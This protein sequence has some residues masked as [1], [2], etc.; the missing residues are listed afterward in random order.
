MKILKKENTKLKK[1]LI[2]NQ[3]EKNNIINDCI[4]QKKINQNQSRNYHLN[5]EYI[6]RCLQT[7][8]NIAISL[9]EKI[10]TYEELI[11]KKDND[12]TKINNMYYKLMDEYENL[13]KNKVS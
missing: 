8:E 11:H 7:Q 3:I 6:K 13:E 9:Q 10:K 2:D 5:E 4:N 1:D 12:Y